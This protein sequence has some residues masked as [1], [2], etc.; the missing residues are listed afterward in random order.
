MKKGRIMRLL[1]KLTQEFR[2][3]IKF[4]SLR[5]ALIRAMGTIV[6][7]LGMRQLSMKINRKRDAFVVEYIKKNYGYVFEKY[8]DCVSND[9]NGS[10]KDAP[11]WIAWLDGVG[12]APPLVKTCIASITKHAGTHP[13][14]IITWENMNEFVNIPTHIIQRAQK[15]EIGLANFSDVLRVS[16][17][18]RHGGMWLDSTIYCSK[19]IPDMYFELP[20]Y[21]CKCTKID[22]RWISKN[23]WTSFVLAGHVNSVFYV[24]LRDFFE[25]YW[26]RESCS[27]DYLLIDA[28]IEVA[29]TTIPCVRQWMEQV[30]CTNE[31]R[32]E[33]ISRFADKW[34]PGCLDDLLQGDT[35]L[36]KLGYREDYYLQEYTKSGDL[37]VYGAFL[38]NFNY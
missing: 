10:P 14:H 12:Q 22:D 31:K 25:H 21:T 36:F 24:A 1:G 18:A 4:Y 20:L 13:V 35:V 33:L 15:G 30:P 28:A 11:I 5:L 27:I 2:Q 19:K 37:S 16:L 7:T 23:Q 17:I 26:G 9:V 6:G 32:D 34:T 8:Y 3:D 29:R 38:R